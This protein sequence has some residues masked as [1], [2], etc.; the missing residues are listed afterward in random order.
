MKNSTLPNMDIQLPEESKV[1]ILTWPPFTSIRHSAL[2]EGH[3]ALRTYCGGP[4]GKGVYVSFWPGENPWALSCAQQN[5]KNN[6]DASLCHQN[7]S[8]FHT[9]DDDDLAYRNFPEVKPNVIDLI[10]LDVK[11]INQNFIKKK[12]SVPEWTPQYNCSDLIFELLEKSGLHQK[13]NVRRYGWK[14]VTSLGI[15]SGFILLD[16]IEFFWA[17]ITTARMKNAFTARKNNKDLFF[18]YLYTPSEWI[19]SR[20]G[21]FPSNPHFFLAGKIADGAIGGLSASFLTSY[22][23]LFSFIKSNIPKDIVYSFVKRDAY[24]AGAI[25]F[26]SPIL[27]YPYL[28]RHL[29]SSWQLKINKKM[30][31]I[32]LPLTMIT[33][34]VLIIGLPSFL[35]YLFDTTTTPRQIYNLVQQVDEKRGVKFIKRQEIKENPE[36]SSQTDKSNYIYPSLFKRLYTDKYK[37]L[38][39]TLALGSIGLFAYRN[40]VDLIDGPDAVEIFEKRG[41]YP[42]TYSGIARPLIF[43]R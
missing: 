17:L 6:E 43:S 35:K 16:T 31:S 25:A 21:I 29:L 40:C 19:L 12:E 15:F 2:S 20:L 26:L 18:A 37:I 34:N 8:H 11:I 14:T 4:E 33:F 9:Q 10:G 23:S 13:V 41:F 7:I 30:S 32:L 38:S 27:Y 39:T 1:T 3:S 28:I 36:S 5:Q 42:A 22:Y 24:I